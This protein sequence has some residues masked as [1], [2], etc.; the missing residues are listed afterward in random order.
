MTALEFA[1]LPN[2][3]SQLDPTRETAAQN[4]DPLAWCVTF[5]PAT[6]ARVRVT[7]TAGAANGSCGVAVINEVLIDATGTDDGVTFVEIA[8]P[9]GALIGGAK[10]EDIE[11]TGVANAGNRNAD[12]DL[13]AG[14]TDGE[15]TIPAGTRI[16]VD[17]ILLVCD[18][19]GTSTTITNVPNASPADVVV[20]DMDLENGGGD[21]VQLVSAAGTLLD[22]VGYAAAATTALDR[23]TTLFNGLAMYEGTTAIY[24]ATASSL[25]RSAT[26][27][28]T[29]DNRTDFAADA[30]PTPGVANN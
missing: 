7:D 8:G 4:D 9:G 2:V 20:R 14:E 29:N 5:Y 10:V 1:A 19:V 28:D 11:G 23:A 21:A 26:S 27:S 16:P 30:T 24:P 17:G 15:I 13:T 3:T 25:A 12:G 18:G 22:V 6:G